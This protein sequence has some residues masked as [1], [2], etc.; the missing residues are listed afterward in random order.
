[1]YSTP[2]YVRGLYYKAIFTA[3]IVNFFN[4]FFYIFQVTS[5]TTKLV[6]LPVTKDELG[7]VNEQI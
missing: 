7:Q 5:H 4:L 6:F 3:L 1:M 2:T